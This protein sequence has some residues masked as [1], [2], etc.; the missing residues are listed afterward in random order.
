VRA[1]EHGDPDAARDIADRLRNGA[2]IEVDETKIAAVLKQQTDAGN[3]EAMRALGPMY[4]RGR[5]VKQDPA[6]G[7]DMLKR[8]VEKGPTAAANGLSRLYLLG[9]PWRAGKPRRVAEMAGRVGRPR[10]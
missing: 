1:A 7:L 8:A 2:S 10:Q 4:I 3:A 5:G 9:A 6:L